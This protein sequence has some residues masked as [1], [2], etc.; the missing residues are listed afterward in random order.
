M[1]RRSKSQPLL[2][3]GC[4]PNKSCSEKGLQLFSLKFHFLF[5]FCRLLRMKMV[6]RK[7]FTF[8]SLLN[9]QLRKVEKL[10]VI[11]LWEGWFTIYLFLSDWV[12]KLYVKH[13]SGKKL[14]SDT[15]ATGEEEASSKVFV[16]NIYIHTFHAVLI[17]VAAVSTRIKLHFY[18]Y[19]PIEYRSCLL[20]FYI[21]SQ[22]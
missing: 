18:L 12:F 3:C 13:V 5:F 6:T 7:T 2:S 15:D 10:K 11:S 21:L 20:E 8:S 4:R 9:L 14:D 17:G 1:N 19:G 22:S 16:A